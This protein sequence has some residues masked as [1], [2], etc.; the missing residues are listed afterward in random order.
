MRY[1]V[2]DHTGCLLCHNRMPVDLMVRRDRRHGC[3][4]ND[5]LR[6]L[7]M[8]EQGEILFD[9]QNLAAAQGESAKVNQK[10]EDKT[11]ASLEQ[12]M[13]ICDKDNIE[14]AIKTIPIALSRCETMLHE[15]TK[16]PQMTHASID[17]LPEDKPE[18]VLELQ[19][20]KHFSNSTAWSLMRNIQEYIEAYV[21]WDW[22]GVTY[23]DAKQHWEDAMQLAENSIRNEMGYMDDECGAHISAN[24]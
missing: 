2:Y 19:V 11:F 23:P 12:F 24:W 18:F 3:H 22:A 14:R 17:N 1:D 16:H 8:F 7:L 4:G 9:V 20:E 10:Q 21:L 5:F 15:W 13:N 6:V